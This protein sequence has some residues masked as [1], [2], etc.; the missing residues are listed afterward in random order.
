[1]ILNIVLVRYFDYL[2]DIFCTANFYW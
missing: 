1:V 2:M